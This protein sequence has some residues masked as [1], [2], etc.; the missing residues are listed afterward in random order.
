MLKDGVA[1]LNHGSFGAVPRAVYEEQD[2]WRRRIEAEPIELLGRRCHDLLAEAKAPI[3]AFLG[4][5]AEE[6]GLVTNAS[7]GINAT[8]R[9]ME[10]RAGEELVTTTH[11]Y[12]AVRQTMRYVAQ[13]SG[14]SFREIAVPTPLRD[15]QQAAEMILA[16]LTERTRL[17]VIDHVSSPTAVVFPVEQIVAGCKA[18]GIEVLVDGAHAP[19]MLDLNV[20]KIGAAYYAGNLHKWVCA[21]KG[22]GFIWAREDRRPQVHPAVIS[23]DWGNGFM[24]EFDWQGTRDISAWLTTPRAIAFMGELGWEK[25]RR[26]NHELVVWAHRML[27]ESWEVQPLTPLDGQLLGSMATVRLPGQLAT[28]KEETAL[29]LQQRLYSE[30]HIEVPFINWQGQWHIR[31]S[32]Q[33]YNEPGDYRR[34]AE[35]IRGEV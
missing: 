18:R 29:K 27:C 34:L 3:G 30:G 13:R 2:R 21:P 32:C 33:V 7:E 28:M 35:A 24:K 6:F 10:I 12:N 8:L 11:V 25:V 20:P 5:K 14:A 1:F 9:S 26:Y 15:G 16:G 23:H 22:S 19:G 17:L 31:V 4:M